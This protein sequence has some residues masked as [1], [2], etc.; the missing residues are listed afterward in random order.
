MNTHNTIVDI[1]FIGSGISTSFS[2]INFLN[3]IEKRGEIDNP[4]SINIIEKYSEFN[5]GIPYGSRSGFSTLLITSLRNFLVKPEL[6]DF[7]KWL[8]ENKSWLLEEFENEGGILSKKWIKDNEKDIKNNRWEELFIPRRFFGCYINLKVNNKVKKLTEKGYVKVNFIKGEVIDIE[9]KKGIYGVYLENQNERI[10]TNKVVLSIGSL[11]T[12]YLWKNKDLIAEK[13]IL[14]VNNPYKPE[15]KVILDNIK[16]FIESR[17]NIKT[18]VLIVGANASALELLYKINDISPKNEKNITYTFLSTQGR[19]P[20]AIIDYER[21]NKFIPENLNNLKKEKKLTAK[22]I[23]DATFKDLDVAD[24]I[25]LGPASTVDTISKYFGALLEKLDPKELEIF[26]CQYG[27]DI[28]KRQRCAGLHYSNVV[29]NLK[30]QQKFE[31]ISGRFKTLSKA[32]DENYALCYIDTATKKEKTLDKYFHIVINCI[33]SKNL[34]S[35]HLPQLHKNLMNKGYCEPNNSKIGFHVNKLLEA[36]KNLYIMGPMLAGNVIDNKAVW[37]VEHCGRIIWISKILSKILAKDLLDQT[38]VEKKEYKLEVVNLD[39]ESTITKYKDLLID[40]WDNN[41]YYAYDHLKYFENSTNSLKCFLL[42][43]NDDNKILM[44]IIFREINFNDENT[45]YFDAITPYGYSGPLYNS[46]EITDSDLS[47]F[48][49][50]VDNWYNKNNVVAEFIR[51][52]LN[53]NYSGYSG[54]LVNTLLNVK[55]KLASDFEKQWESF[56][57]KVRNNYRKA[58]SFN[59][60]FKIYSDKEINEEVIKTFSNIYTST[61]KRHNAK[62]IYFFSSTYFKNLILNN[63][64]KFS[65][66]MVHVDNVAIST[67]LIINHNKTLSA[68]LGGTDSNY[69]NYRPNDFLRVEVIK[70]AIKNNFKHYVLG[71]GLSDGDGLYKSKKCLFPKDEDKVF[72]TGRKIINHEVYDFLCQSHVEGYENIHKDEMKN[73]FFPLYRLNNQDSS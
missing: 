40:N 26:A 13:N 21:Q 51:F 44:P 6:S 18:N 57:P 20:D 23:A 50:L 73:Y 16:N 48:W 19:V 55:G 12:N 63:L 56:L 39:E 11:P 45:N 29:E 22:I 62:S 8:N 3:A 66:A 47:A 41:I 32:K 31:H 60:K 64:E 43:I 28:G 30:S 9:R 2:I 52:S 54:L 67:E 72:Y 17:E 59:L 49:K 53:E 69:Y 46:N 34:E 14:F 70:W 24:E 37:H 33:G 42:K 38:K 25:N 35:K 1:T 61:M 65:I 58:S 27:N 71:G 15:L 36:S 4:I 10:D 7:I 5:L 68:F